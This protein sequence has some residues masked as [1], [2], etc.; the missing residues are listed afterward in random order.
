MSGNDKTQ[1]AATELDLNLPM[2]KR[3]AVFLPLTFLAV[4]EIIR[5]LLF[6]HFFRSVPGYVVAAALVLVAAI[7]FSNSVFGL[8]ARMRHRLI[9]Q[10]QE[11]LALHDAGLAVT[12][13]LDLQ[14]VLQNVV[15]EARELVGARYGAL[16][17]LNDR[18]EIGEFLTSGIS[19]E[20]RASLGPIPRGRGLL[21]A[22][23]EDPRPLRL[24]DLARDS[25]SVGFP[26]RHPAMHSLLAVP[27]L[28]HSNVL[29]ALYLTERQG[30]A[31]FDVSDQER[32]ERFATQAALAI[33]NAHLHQQV[34][35]LAIAEERD[36]I[37]R[38]MHDSI[39]QVLA[40]VNT[41]GQAAAE[42]LRA[43]DSVRAEQ[44][45][46]QLAEAARDAYADVR[47]NILG[48]RVPHGEPASLLDT[49]CTYLASWQDQCGIATT[50]DH[51][52]DDDV[53][54]SLSPLDEL[55][56]LRIVQEALSNVR[57]HANASKVILSLTNEDAAIVIS[58]SD[59]GTGFDPEA[60][61]RS[62]FPRFGMATMR[63]RAESIGGQ[64]NVAS[65]PSEG[66]VVTARIPVQSSELSQNE[67][68]RART[69]S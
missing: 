20:L 33:E 9:Q 24:R 7:L 66:T 28:S 4:I 62:G 52:V 23:L 54:S 53:I 11:L 25:R 32:L 45:I 39:S 40:Y 1:R 38:E 68:K 3:M 36:R 14:L 10:N 34:K 58:V 12:S 35:A 30:Q 59:N 6:P 50:F 8:V 65:R 16:A 26:P 15:N 29:G 47:E 41:K 51:S 64:V 48:L 46:A 22:V 43:G 60:I 56:V 5:E 57:K 21:G 61:G 42:L 18:S 67:V 63:E 2:L 37:A 27:I 55:Q 19:P 69:H 49:L 44:Q 31:E 17:L 13:A